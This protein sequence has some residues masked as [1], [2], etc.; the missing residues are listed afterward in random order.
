MTSVGFPVSRLTS[1]HYIKSGRCIAK[2]FE[3]SPFLT[4]IVRSVHQKVYEGPLKQPVKAVKLFSLSTCVATLVGSPILLYFGKE[5]VPLVAKVG[6]VGIVGIIGIGS[7][8]LLHWFTK[9]YVRGMSYDDQTDTIQIETLSVFAWPL[10]REFSV[11]DVKPIEGKRVFS[12][13]SVGDRHYFIH[14]EV[15]TDGDLLARLLSLGPS[16]DEDKQPTEDE[17]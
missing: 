15:F 11:D 1:F 3:N 6:M 7:T 16:L 8:A 9:G 12:N 13:F 4:P 14:P 5:S 10:L 2:A 17:Q